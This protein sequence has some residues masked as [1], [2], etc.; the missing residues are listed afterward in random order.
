MRSLLPT[1]GQI[2]TPTRLFLTLLIL[3]AL[4]IP[5]PFVILA[6]GT[7]QNVLGEAIKISGTKTYPTTGKLSVTSVMVT[8]PDSYITGF[9]IFYGWLDN[10]RAVLPRQ[11][12]YPDGETAAEAVKQGAAEMNGSQINA[13][14]AALS[15]L[16]YKSASKLAVVD[17]NK[18]S[19]AQ[20]VILVN[21]QVLTIDDR[22]FENTTELLQFLDN[23]KPGDYVTVKVNRKGVELTKKIALSS[24]DDGS[25]FIGIN[26]Q[27]QFVFP[28]DVKIKLEETG[29]PSGGLI[30]AIGV[31][32]KLTAE[33]LI[34]SRNIAG[35]GTITTTGNVGPIGG[36][37]EKIIGARDFGVEIFFTPIE[38]CQD[39]SNIEALGQGKGE[40]AMKIVPVATLAEAIAVLKLPEN[41]KFPTCKSYA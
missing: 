41:S 34:R 28:F 32:D 25:A 22:K 16:G 13:T 18:E 37:A 5:S 33:D 24:R 39:I 14:A 19:K 35:T 36:I 31:V 27:E 17:V 23:K 6:P 8:D 30:F 9:D 26:I 15:Y 2:P 12:V 7:P 29:G 21:D 40:K 4:F 3:V 1:R 20:N 11:E 38:N 10:Q